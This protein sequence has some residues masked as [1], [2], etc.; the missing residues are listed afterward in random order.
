MIDVTRV[1]AVDE[2][3]VT[4]IARLVRQLSSSAPLPGPDEIREIVASPCTVLLIA[5]DR[6]AGSCI[7]GTLTLALFRIPTGIRAWIEDVVVEAA[8]RGTGVGAAL[9]REAL[10]IANER[11]ART[12]E[13][14]SRPSRAAANKLYQKLGFVAR[15]TNIYRYAP[16]DPLGTSRC[17]TR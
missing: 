14:T 4:A 17:R 12:V 1:V 9:S 15:D 8:A 16:N 2:E 5:R 13:L 3:M 7:I 6:A 11:G 10:R